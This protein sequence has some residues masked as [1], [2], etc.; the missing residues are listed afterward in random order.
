MEYSIYYRRL[1]FVFF[2][3]QYQVYGNIKIWW[4]IKISC[5]RSRAKG[6]EI[7]QRSLTSMTHANFFPQTDISR[8]ERNATQQCY[9]YNINDT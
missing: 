3:L 6:N 4:N 8:F 1:Q 9:M 7:L 2:F 5:L